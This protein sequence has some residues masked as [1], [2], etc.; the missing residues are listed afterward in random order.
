[1]GAVEE[2]LTRAGGREGMADMLSMYKS[3]D[4]PAKKNKFIK[5]SIGRKT[6]NA[7][8]EVWINALLSSPH[9]QIVNFT[10][11]IVTTFGQIPTKVVAVGIGGISRTIT[12][13]TDGVRMGEGAAEVLQAIQSTKKAIMLAGK[14][15]KTG[16]KPD[17]L[18]GSKLDQQKPIGL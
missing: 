15:L 9:T 17:F 16:Q 18:F 14:T 11:N 13:A 3:L 8:Y 6:F 7:L 4:T 12:G 2:L 5:D 1:M 10:A